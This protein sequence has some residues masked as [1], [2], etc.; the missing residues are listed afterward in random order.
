MEYP[1]GQLASVVL[2]LSPHDFLCNPSLLSSWE[3]WEAWFPCCPPLRP[4][5]INSL[6]NIIHS[7]AKL[8]ICAA[9]LHTAQS[10][11]CPTVFPLIFLC[12]FY[13]ELP[14]YF[15]G[16]IHSRTVTWDGYSWDNCCREV[17]EPPLTHSPY[18]F[19]PCTTSSSFVEFGLHQP[20]SLL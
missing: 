3:A 14:S 16:H 17:W 2:A 12:Q 11:H 13:S 20:T 4:W 5:P 7:V 19:Q 10:S 15:S 1:S 6:T 9:L 18:M 8:W